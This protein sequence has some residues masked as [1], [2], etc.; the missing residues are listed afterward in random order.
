MAVLKRLFLGSI[1]SF[2]FL[3]FA[4]AWSDGYQHI[5][6]KEYK[7][8]LLVL[9]KR[10]GNLYCPDK[11]SETAFADCRS[12]EILREQGCYGYSTAAMR[13]ESR[14]S[15]NCLELNKLRNTQTPK[16]SYFVLDNKTWWQDLPATIIP[17]SGGV[18][19]DES[20][21]TSQRKR[22]TLVKD[23]RLKDLRLHKVSTYL[24]RVEIVIA[25][26]KLECGKVE[27]YLEIDTIVLA[28]FNHDEI[29]ELIL[30]GHRVD[31]SDTCPLG[32][33][34]SLGAT[35]MAVLAKEGKTRQI[36]HLF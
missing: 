6:I 2:L 7:E 21:K 5:S 1:T 22:D 32:A 28:D 16:K 31:R 30:K 19:S 36:K 25:T 3:P 20:W 33:A 4:L 17:I 27:D 9:E 8:A 29:A 26:K 12:F 11:N 35:F 24:D 23:K 15:D 18:Y 14:Y 13:S 10:G 34:N